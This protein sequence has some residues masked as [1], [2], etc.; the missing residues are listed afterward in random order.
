VSAHPNDV[1]NV[2][3]ICQRGGESWTWQGWRRWLAERAMAR[4]LATLPDARFRVTV[5]S[6]A[7]EG[8]R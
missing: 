3:V 7:K 5:V 2:D 6:E 1:V 4:T 8:S